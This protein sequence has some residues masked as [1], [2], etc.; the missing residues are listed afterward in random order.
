MPAEPETED[1]RYRAVLASARRLSEGAL[2]SPEAA[3]ASLCMATGDMQGVRLGYVQIARVLL[4]FLGFAGW[5]LALVLWLDSAQ[6]GWQPGLALAPFLFTVFLWLSF[7]REELVARWLYKRLRRREGDQYAGRPQPRSLLELE[8]ATTYAAVKE[9][10]EDLVVATLDPGQG[11]L[12]LEGV[13]H[14]YFVRSADVVH[15]EAVCTHPVPAAT[16]SFR[17]DAETELTVALSE[18]AGLR[19]VLQSF[20]HA[21]LKLVGLGAWI[22]HP[23]ETFA[24]KLRRAL[25]FD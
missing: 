19:S 9:V 22:P 14:R 15:L 16:L 8:H 11:A 5:D 24:R 18:C 2:A 23:G 7:A 3:G 21:P 13:S 20:A 17:L 6:K 1:F 25:A 10:P 4:F 12:R